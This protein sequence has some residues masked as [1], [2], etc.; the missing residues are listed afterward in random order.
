MPLDTVHKNPHA[1][2]DK[3]RLNNG[4]VFQ[5]DGFTRDGDIRLTNGFVVPKHYGHMA[6]G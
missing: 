4:A 1:K 3:P 6:Y 5:V 2:A